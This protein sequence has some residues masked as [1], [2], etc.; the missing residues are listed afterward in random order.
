MVSYSSLSNDDDSER[1][2]SE[3]SSSDGE[4]SYRKYIYLVAKIFSVIFIV[5][6]TYSAWA[7]FFALK[8]GAIRISN[9][10]SHFNL[11]LVWGFFAT[12]GVLTALLMIWD[13]FVESLEDF[14]VAKKLKNRRLAPHYE[15]FFVSVV[16]EIPQSAILL[17]ALVRYK[18][19][20]Q[21]TQG[22]A[23]FAFVHETAVEIT[24]DSLNVLFRIIGA[25]NKL[26]AI[27]QDVYEHRRL[28]DIGI[29]LLDV[30]VV[31]AL[32]AMVIAGI[33][34]KDRLKF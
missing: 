17:Y 32:I 33:I 20:M 11:K 31:V 4:K 29:L 22:A 16:E 5:W 3:K 28:S 14:Q 7:V 25:G 21:S 19:A 18:V 27:I 1:Q 34:F 12:V 26:W 2:D 13:M 24:L 23:T 15:L 9:E 30:L 8:N 6:D 10:K